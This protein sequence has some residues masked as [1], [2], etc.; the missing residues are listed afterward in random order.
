MKPTGTRGATATAGQHATPARP[1]N[2]TAPFGK[3]GLP[4]AWAGYPSFP[5]PS[6]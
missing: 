3:L 2:T 6:P 1:L 4:P 5:E